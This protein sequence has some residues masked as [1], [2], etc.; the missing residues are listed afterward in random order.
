MKLAW[1]VGVEVQMQSF[2]YYYGLKNL[3]KILEHSDYLLKTIQN[4][5]LTA[6]DP[7]YQATCTLNTLQSMQFF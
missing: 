3:E 2:E 6:T 7:K 4:Q 5:D 1:I